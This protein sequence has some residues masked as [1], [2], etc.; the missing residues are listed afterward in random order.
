MAPASRPAGQRSL[1]ERLRS[2]RAPLPLRRALR[3][4]RPQVGL[5]EHELAKRALQPRGVYC[6]PGLLLPSDTTVYALLAA[7][8]RAA[9]PIRADAP[10]SACLALLLPRRAVAAAASA[11]LARPLRR[12]PG[13]LTRAPR[14][15][16]AQDFNACLP[17]GPGRPLRPHGDCGAD[18]VACRVRARRGA[19]LDDATAHSLPRR[20]QDTATLAARANIT[21][22]A[23]RDTRAFYVVQI[24]LDLLTA[25]AAPARG[26]CSDDDD[27]CGD[28]GP[29]E[30]ASW[31]DA[32]PMTPP[33]SAASSAVRRSGDA[34]GGAAWRERDVRICGGVNEEA[35]TRVWLARRDARGA[36][37]SCDAPNGDAKDWRSVFEAC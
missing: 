25:A 11:R 2:P 34:R 14:P 15:A 35:V 23:A 32:Q 36:F 13:G 6:R 26:D 21:H 3:A 31:R 18:M 24:E 29:P 30:Q 20:A 28:L 8:A 17:L 37:L 33:S 1:G 19:S 4:A 9:A 5:P 22:R 10:R 7:Q 27:D 16:V 12:A